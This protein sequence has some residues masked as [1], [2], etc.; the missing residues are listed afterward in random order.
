MRQ[1]SAFGPPLIQSDDK[2]M[3]PAPVMR[4]S[5]W[6]EESYCSKGIGGPFMLSETW[7][8]IPVADTKRVPDR[9]ICTFSL[10]CNSQKK[11]P[12]LSGVVKLAVRLMVELEADRTMGTW[13]KSY[14]QRCPNHSVNLC[15]LV[16]LLMLTTLV[17]SL[18]AGDTQGY[19]SLL[20]THPSFGYQ[21]DRIQ[22][23]A[24]HLAVN[25]WL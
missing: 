13:R 21:R 14:H 6:P 5:F 20:W 24:L 3:L 25:L 19:S 22:S 4:S 17:I 16:V 12:L 2:S 8:T 10:I 9:C 18:H 7:W 15:T 11:A 23:K 1:S